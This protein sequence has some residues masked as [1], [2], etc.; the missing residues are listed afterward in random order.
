M[1]TPTPRTTRP[2]RLIRATAA[3]LATACVTATLLP[4]SAAAQRRDTASAASTASVL[5]MTLLFI[6]PALV[7]G[8]STELVIKSVEAGSEASVWVLERASDGARASVRFANDVAGGLS[9]AAGATVLVSATAA[10]WVLHSGGKA[11]GFV[12][13]DAGRRLLHNERMTP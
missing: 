5:P 7:L 9:L 4:A 8:A 1:K 3:L 13:N 11:I 6:S 12:A 10:G 2:H